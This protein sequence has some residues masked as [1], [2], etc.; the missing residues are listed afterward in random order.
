RW[1]EPDRRLVG[2]HWS[3]DLGAREV[4]LELA[5]A[6]NASAVLSRFSRLLVDPNRDEHHADAFRTLADGE[7][8]LLNTGMTAEDRE[9]RLAGYHRPYHEALDAAL[10][11]VD[12]PIL[13]SIHSFTPN[14]QGELRGVEIGV[15]FDHQEREAHQLGAVLSE[16]FE[17]VAYNEPWS[18]RAGLIY[19][20]ERH[21]QKH[22]R[23]AL[24]LEVRQDRAV[25]PA[26]RARLIPK[27]AEFFR[28]KLGS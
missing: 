22:G 1:P 25:D 4:T 15:L 23:L 9:R 5:R 14:Y 20:A 28:S 7:P 27:L 8:V 26:F 19:S 13:F 2:T 18:G 17:R 10:A 11:A 16:E 3:Y 21:S 24:E 12:A 6:L